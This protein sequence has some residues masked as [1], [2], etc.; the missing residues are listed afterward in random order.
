MYELMM[1]DN[2]TVNVSMAGEAQQ[3][4]LWLHVHDMSI[5]ECAE[6]FSD[7]ANTQT[8]H[9]EYDEGIE[10]TFEGYTVLISVSVCGDFVKVG[11]EKNA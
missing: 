10:S 8:M 6:T 5:L 9:I 11:M 7:P 3:G 1:A 4:G 2:S